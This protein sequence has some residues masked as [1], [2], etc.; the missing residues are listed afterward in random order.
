MQIKQ[1]IYKVKGMRRDDSYSSFKP[2]FSWENHNIRLTARDNN[3]L[4]SVTNERGNVVIGHNEYTRDPSTVVYNYTPLFLNYKNTL[5]TP[6]Y[7]YSVGFENYKDTL[8]TPTY[9]YV[10]DFENYKD[11]LINI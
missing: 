1:S 11:T 10:P 3:D 8:A 6:V 9:S 2:E 7:S 4:L 5:S